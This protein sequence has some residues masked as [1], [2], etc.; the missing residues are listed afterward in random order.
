MSEPVLWQAQVQ[1]ILENLTSFSFTK[2]KHEQFYQLPSY[3]NYVDN[4]FCVCVYAC[5]RMRACACMCVCAH[6]RVCVCVCVCV[7][8]GVYV[9]VCARVCL[10]V[11]LSVD[12][13]M[14]SRVVR[15]I[16]SNFVITVTRYYYKQQKCTVIFV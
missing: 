1:C 14:R 9:R 11:H 15:R 13:T 8:V 6:A 16:Q 5:L 4:V 2:E 12:T 3:Y 7:C 10:P